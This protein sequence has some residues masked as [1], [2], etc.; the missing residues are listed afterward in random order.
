[1]PYELAQRLRDLLFGPLRVLRTKCRGLQL[2]NFFHKFQ[3]N[4]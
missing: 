1:M 4:L 2:S 3:R